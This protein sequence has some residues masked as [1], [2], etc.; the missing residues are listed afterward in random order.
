M[1]IE[2]TKRRNLLISKSKSNGRIIPKFVNFWHFDSFP[3]LLIS[4]F[5]KFQKF[6][7]RKILKIKFYNLESLKKKLIW[8]INIL[9]FEKLSNILG[10]PMIYKK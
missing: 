5:G 2:K 1:K 4:Q 8:K 6:L 3:N 7:I 10:V 9:E